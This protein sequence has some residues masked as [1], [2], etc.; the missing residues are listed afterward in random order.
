MPQLLRKR[1]LS[2]T[3]R[4]KVQTFDPADHGTAPAEYLKPLSDMELESVL[5]SPGWSRRWKGSSEHNPHLRPSRARG[6]WPDPG[7]Y[8]Q[9]LRKDAVVAAA[10]EQRARNL[11]AL[12]WQIVP[13]AEPTP[14]EEEITQYVRDVF[15]SLHGGL[16]GLLYQISKR[17]LY[18]FSLL[19]QV[20]EIEESTL[21]YRLEELAF[22]EPCTVFKWITN[23]AG[24]LVGILQRGEKGLIPI[25]IEKLAHFARGF[26]GR[27]W[28]GVS[29]LR[30]AYYAVSAKQEVCQN[31]MAS[32][33]LLGEGWL[34][35]T[36]DAE[37]GSQERRELEDTLN[38]WSE[39]EQRWVIIPESV[40]INPRHGGSVLPPLGPPVQVFNNEI[41]RAVGAD[42]E[43]LGTQS[44]GSRALGSEYRAASNQALAG[45]ATELA[46]LIHSQIIQP[47]CHLNGWPIDRSPRIFAKGIGDD[48]TVQGTIAKARLI[49]EM[50][51]DGVIT[52]ERA[53]EATNRALD[54]LDF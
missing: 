32:R 6:L 51:R 54:L 31:S 29:L 13:P 45:E 42:L 50:V 20:Y 44:H 16:S 21:R 4:R 40:Q 39:A 14:A 36:C 1:Q 18:G 2:P 28:E 34:E 10:I 22:I 33:Q 47:M 37:P 11:I 30:A 41:S 52:P 27:N 15:A 38:Q 23:E 26:T 17:D 48:K 3:N 43:Q 49:L 24:Y 12:D 7:L 53:A 19:E 8:S 5:S 25:P 35:V 9:M 46:S